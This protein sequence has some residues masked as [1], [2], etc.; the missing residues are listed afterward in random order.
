MTLILTNIIIAIM[1][2]TYE[3][4]MTKIVQ[5]DY[6]EINNMMM[7]YENVLIRNRDKGS[8]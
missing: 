1:T 4:V 8:P 6:K 2:D 5:S 3:Q 7:N